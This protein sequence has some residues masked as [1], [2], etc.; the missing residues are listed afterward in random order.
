MPGSKSV[1]AEAKIK[2]EDSY[3]DFFRK[4]LFV[5]STWKGEGLNYKK[6]AASGD[7]KIFIPEVLEVV[8]GNSSNNMHLVIWELFKYWNHLR[9]RYEKIRRCFEQPWWH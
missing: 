6:V 8:L 7:D 5:V 1:K 2:S 3:L 4:N 9:F